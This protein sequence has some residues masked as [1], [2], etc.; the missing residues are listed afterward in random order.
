[1]DLLAQLQA[2]PGPSGDEG[3]IAEFVAVYCRGIPGTEVRVISD[4][5]LAT[6]G[7]PRVAVFAHTDTIGF[8]QAYERRLVRLGGPRVSGGERVREVDGPGRAR[9]KLR[10]KGEKPEWLLS[11]KA[12]RPGS[13]WVFADPLKFKKDRVTG[14]YLD[15]RAGVWNALRTLERCDNV[16]VFFTPGEEHSG[17][18]AML[19]A[20]LAHEELE[21]S[22]ALISD[23]T[24]DTEWIKNGNG[25]AVSLRD[26]LAPRR[27]FLDRVLQCAEASGIPFQYEV[28][29][30]GGSDG[31]ALERSGY[32][33]DWVFVGAPQ[34]DSHTPHEECRVSD[35]HAM[36]DLYAYLVP[37]LS[38][39]PEGTL[40]G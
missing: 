4:L 6:R 34:K 28:E 17:R 9:I 14:P 37:A 3:A 30:D 29:T 19:G 21:I 7:E 40:R 32:P 27:Q 1:M 38:E 33:V 35:L 18:G 2:I 24:C 25:P 11:E 10:T 22:Q 39:A 36:A 15:N 26:R 31:H 12:G 13:R 23:I 5:V 20:R 16:A 8:T